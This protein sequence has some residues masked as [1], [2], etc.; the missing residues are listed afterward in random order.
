MEK[1]PPLHLPGGGTEGTSLEMDLCQSRRT[2]E[3]P[4]Q[5]YPTH[6]FRTGTAN[7]SRLTSQDRELAADRKGVESDKESPRPG[8]DVREATTKNDGDANGAESSAMAALHRDVKNARKDRNVS[9]AGH[10][11]AAPSVKGTMQKVLSRKRGGR[12]VR[13]GSGS[14]GQELTSLT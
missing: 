2:G 10:R 3:E 14:G 6:Q 4:L 5:A 1:D 9:V 7:P 13:K 11:N 8:V 12:R